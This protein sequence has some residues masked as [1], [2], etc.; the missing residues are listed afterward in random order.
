ME[1]KDIGKR[2]RRKRIEKDGARKNWQ[3]RWI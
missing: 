2:I 3:K 1:M